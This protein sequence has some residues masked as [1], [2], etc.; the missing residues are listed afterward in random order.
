MAFTIELR[1]EGI[2]IDDIEH[3]HRRSHT[4]EQKPGKSKQ[5]YGTPWDLIRAVEKRFGTFVWDLAATKENAKAPRFITPEEDSLKVDWPTGGDDARGNL[6]LNCEFA[7]ISPWAKKCAEHVERLAFGRL[8]VLLTPAS[9]GANWFFN[10]VHGR[11]L[12][13]PLRPRFAFEGQPINPKTGK[14]D[15]YPKDC[16]I[17]VFGEKPGFEPWKWK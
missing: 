13:I 9:V 8:L 7:H 15:P 1:K 2:C 5:D 14:A 16:M 6:W 3:P 11:A 17:S 10:Y 12:V 4:P